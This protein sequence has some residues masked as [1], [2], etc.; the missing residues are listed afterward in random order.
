MMNYMEEG[1]Q[2][3]VE[4]KLKQMASEL[5]TQRTILQGLANHQVRRPDSPPQARD[6][7]PSRA[8]A[9]A[10]EFAL[11]EDLE[12]ERFRANLE[13]R[14]QARKAFLLADNKASRSEERRSVEV[15]RAVAIIRTASC[16]G[17]N[18]HA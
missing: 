5:Q 3:G 2:E 6:Q 11:G 18:G 15:A 8:K 7:P 14:T 1:D 16:I 17:L 13:R 10:H 9:A 4:A 12:S